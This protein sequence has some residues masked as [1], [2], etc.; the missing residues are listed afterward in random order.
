MKNI[1]GFVIEG[2]VTTVDQ[3]KSIDKE[4]RQTI[5]K[6]KLFLDVLH[7]KKNMLS[8]IG[9]EKR[10]GSVLYERAERTP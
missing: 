8:A 9:S 10:Q 7:V 3:E 5:S 6:D 4:F 1:D 2:R